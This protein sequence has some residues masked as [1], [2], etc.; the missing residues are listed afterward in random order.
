MYNKAK[1]DNSDL[2]IC[3]M[4]DNYENG[5]KKYLNCTKFTSVYTVTPSA[6]NKSLFSKKILYKTFNF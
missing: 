2:V 3:D 6:S 5:T 4:T 1:Q